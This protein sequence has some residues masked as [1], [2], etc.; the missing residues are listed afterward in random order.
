MNS[1]NEKKKLR[2]LHSIMALFLFAVVN[3]QV[4][5]PLLFPENAYTTETKIVRTT[6]GE[7]VVVYRSYTHLLYVTKP[8]DKDYQSLNVSVP[9]KIDDHEINA[10]DS[11]ILFVI[12]V[13]GYSSVRNN[14]SSAGDETTGRQN[15]PNVSGQRGDFL[16]SRPGSGPSETSSL[17]SRADLALAAGFVVITPGCRGRENKTPDGT[18]FGKAPAAIVDLK[19]A[20]RYVKHNKGI[21]PGNTDHIVS[22]GVSAGGALSALLGSSGNSPLFDSYL[23]NIGAA[24]GS[25]DI[26]ASACFC[27]ITDLENADGAYEWMYGKV[28]TRSGLVDQELSA[29]LVKKYIGYQS[30]L[31]LL[32]KD[33]FGFVTADNYSGYLLKY[34]LVPSARKFLDNLND[35]KRQEYL[36]KNPWLHYSNNELTFSFPDYAAHV[37]RMKGLP[38]FDD[39]EMRQPEPSLFGNEATDARHFTEFSQQHATGDVKAR[40][41]EDIVQKRNM[42]NAMYFIENKNSSCAGHWWIR[43]G[44]SDN[45]TSQTVIINLALRLENSGKDVNTLLYW[46]AGH[47]AD[48][49]PGDFINWILEITSGK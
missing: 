25:D 29:T 9:V 18:N 22:V 19:A 44:T 13:G 30:S 10:A 11:P 38:A 33:N 27:P 37:G 49:D 23:K 36:L 4:G 41:D 16:P 45:H 7:K 3:G 2:F 48:E 47:G 43:H 21:I 20:V 46:D 39:F 40:I 1:I 12:G 24:G 28:P 14:N 31:K 17:S 42:M 5:D 35:G 15:Q 26:F 34:Y 8:I 6:R 32:G